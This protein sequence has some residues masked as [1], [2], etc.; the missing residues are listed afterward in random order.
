MFTSINNMVLPPVTGELSADPLRNVAPDGLTATYLSTIL[1]T[2]LCEASVHHARVPN[3]SALYTG[4]SMV[5]I[6]W[7]LKRGGFCVHLHLS[8]TTTGNL[9]PDY[10]S[11]ISTQ[12]WYTLNQLPS[13]HK[14]PLML[15]VSQTLQFRQNIYSSIASSVTSF[16]RPLRAFSPLRSCPDSPAPFRG[17]GP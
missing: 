1:H 10:A 2:P 13:G 9:L 6:C 7:M 3:T 14:S 12:P 5:H 11:G 8:V 4:F 15:I 16:I 17:P